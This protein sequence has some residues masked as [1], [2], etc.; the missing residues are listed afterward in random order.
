MDVPYAIRCDHLDQ[1]RQI[2]SDL[3]TLS[4]KPWLISPMGGYL[5]L[6]WWQ[7]MLSQA[8]DWPMLLDCG[9]SAGLCM[10]A[11]RLRIPCF[12]AT[13][14]APIAAKIADMAQ[15]VGC[16]MLPPPGEIRNHPL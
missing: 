6:G 3:A 11:I 7:I 15:Q 2:Q 1:L 14:P 4:P 13:L 16:R 5:G 8:K 10:A 12:C 9:H